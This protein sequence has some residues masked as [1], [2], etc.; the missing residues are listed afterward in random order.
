[1]DKSQFAVIGK[2]LPRIDGRPKSTGE[3]QYAA[4]VWLPGC[5]SGRILRSPY[6]HAR[7][8]NIDTSKAEALK[9]VKAVMTAKNVPNVHF[10]YWIYDETLFKSDKVRYIGDEVAAVAAVDE[11]TAQEAIE[12]IRVEWEELPAVLAVEEALTPQASL[13][14]EDFAGHK[15]GF[16]VVGRTGNQACQV[17]FHQGDVE[18]GF[19]QADEIIENRFRTQSTHPTYLETHAALATCDRTG[20]LTVWLTTQ[21]VF[22]SQELIAKLLDLPLSRVRVIGTTVGGGFGGK[23]PRVEQYAAAL[24]FHT[25]KP[26]RVVLSREEDLAM[27]FR[28]HPTLT[29]VKSGVKRDGTLTAWDFKMALD[30]GAYADHG[31]SIAA[32]SAFHGCG[33]YKIPHINCEA[34]LVY[35]NKSISGAFRGYGN[36]QATFAVESQMDIIA[37]T[38]GMDPIEL[39]RKNALGPNDPRVNGQQYPQIWLRETLD[40]A[41]KAFGWENRNRPSQ[42]GRKRGIGVACGSHPT[43]GLG[44]SAMVKL[45]ADGTLQVVSGVIEIGGGEYTVVAQVAAEAFG[46]PYERVRVV[47][48]DTDGTGYESYTA[49]SRSTFNV[50]RVVRLAALDAREEML[51]RAA[52]M[53]EVDPSDLKAKGERVFVASSPDRSLSY[54]EVSKAANIYQKG[55]IQGK[56]SF[57]FRPPP[58]KP[59][60]I[61]GAALKEFPTHGFVTHIAEVEVDEE[62]GEVEVLRMVCSHDIGQA[63]NPGGLEGQIEGGVTQGLGYALLE[64]LLF[65]GGTLSNGTL[66]DYK[67]PNILDVPPIEYH[68]VERADPNG[69]YGAK[70]VGESVLVPTAPAV[71]N[72]VYD[73]IGARV[74]ALPLTPERVLGAL[75]ATGEGQTRLTR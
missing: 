74:K 34:R 1:M 20:Q 50:G 32:N 36:P 64:E 75:Q 39:R 16:E 54:A 52:E 51:Q 56:A 31:P 37:R 60:Q 27:A 13:V 59:E 57:A 6:P 53:L 70:G 43:G 15:A 4:D 21:A 69:P 8:L 48:A 12:A 61:E 33:P 46:V 68:F 23:K 71:A 25:R 14:H 65:E 55:P 18:V 11:D 62:T 29:D 19:S 67:I 45:M 63:I 73:A 47:A 66:V 41:A 24:A 28:R 42:N 7:I 72:A 35:T 22:K 17:R 9:G 40:Q 5:L 38:L 2:S 30:T 44:S 10:G 49:A 3:A 58:V 26:V